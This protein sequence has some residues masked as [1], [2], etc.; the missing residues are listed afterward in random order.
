MAKKKQRVVAPFLG[1][2]KITG[3]QRRKVKVSADMVTE[4]CGVVGQREK[5]TNSASSKKL[6]FFQDI[7]ALMSHGNDKTKFEHSDD[8]CFLLVQRSSLVS[9]VSKLLCPCCLNAGTN[10]IINKHKANGFAAWGEIFCSHC[11]AVI[12]GESLCQCVGQSSSSKAPFEINLRATLAFRGIGCGFSA[13]KEW[14][15]LMN[16]PHSLSQDT[17]TKCHDKLGVKAK[18][19][20]EGIQKA[21]RNAVSAAYKDIGIVPDAEGLLDI[22][23]SYDGA[24]QRRG[25]SSHNG[26][27]SVIDLLTGL[28][29]DY[30]VLS[31]FCLKCK[32]AE[33]MP[34]DQAWKEKHKSN[35]PKNFGGTSNAMEVECAIKL[36]QR[37]KNLK[38]RYQT[39]LCDGDSKA[40]DAVVEASVYGKDF[41]VEKEDCINHVSKRM[42]TALRNLVT[43]SRA[44]KESITGKGKLTQKKM[45]KIQNYYGR[46]IKDCGDDIT[47]MK[48]RIFAILFHLCSSDDHPKHVH[49]PPGERSWCFWQR[50][51][52][53]GKEPG[54]HKVIGKKLVPVFTRLTE[55]GLLKRCV[56]G[57][58]QNTNESLH[59]LIWKLCPK[60]IFSGR[61]TL[62]C[63]VALAVS[64]FSSGA[65]FKHTLLR[66]FMIEPGQY[67]IRDSCVKDRKRIKIAVKKSS[68]AFKKR[69]K[70]L[71]YKKTSNEKATK[72]VEGETYSPGAFLSTGK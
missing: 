46:A 25:H 26:V 20:F 45:E 34:E 11:E 69:R 41:V 1:R 30:E 7:E 10:I 56:R 49:C 21:S 32:I 17:Y 27:G 55:Q 16:M 38:L 6:G 65:T 57:Q 44:Q 62:E 37:S 13:V 58:T 9:L 12:C 59:N 50:A 60:V 63:A 71:K 70:Q 68:E 64:Q 47:T 48:S 18:E 40:Y 61:K 35:C 22:A 8:D 42:G 36:W 66:A 15:S 51:V 14:C 43:T 19:T 52:A 54:P 29:L 39:M 2:K 28:P 4:A 5:Q 23:V 3:R 33:D 72:A 67:T 53:E 31:N 24:W